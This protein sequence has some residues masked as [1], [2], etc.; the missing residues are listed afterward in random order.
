MR[1][2]RAT[3]EQIYPG[4]AVTGRAARLR[5][6]RFRG[7]GHDAEPEIVAGMR[8]SFEDHESTAQVRVLAFETPNGWDYLGI[9]ESLTN[10]TVPLNIRTFGASAAAIDLDNAYTA[11]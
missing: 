6:L 10:E 8:S 4:N 3:G 1:V 9:V 5:L 11:Y 2:Y 7:V